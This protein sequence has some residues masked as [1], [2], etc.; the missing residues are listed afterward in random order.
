MSMILGFPRGFIFEP[1]H[2]EFGV[3]LGAVSVSVMK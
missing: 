3:V 2:C 1:M